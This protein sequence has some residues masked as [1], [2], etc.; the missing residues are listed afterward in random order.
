MWQCAAREI[1]EGNARATA[2][3]RA[4]A[5]SSSEDEGVWEVWASK[6]IAGDEAERGEEERG[7]AEGERGLGGSDGAGPELAGLGDGWSVPWSV[8]F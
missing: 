4:R 5:P 2:V 8:L 6:D 7:L 1:S 3:R